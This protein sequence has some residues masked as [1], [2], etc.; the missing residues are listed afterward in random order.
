MSPSPFRNANN[1]RYTNGLFYEAPGL[2]KSACIFTLKDHDYQTP[3][4]RPLK[5]LYLLYMAAR[6]VTEYNFAMSNLDG[7]EHWEMLCSATFFK[8]FVARWRQELE[9]LI[10]AECLNHIEAISKDPDHKSQFAA[11]NFLVT[12]GWREKAKSGKGRP[13]KAQVQQ[14]ARDLAET[15]KRLEEDYA[16]IN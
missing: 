3:D 2:D 11:L 7:W 9:L 10:K 16:R 13:T 15:N 6:D 1:Q 4:G 5:S 14:A 12:S 8:P